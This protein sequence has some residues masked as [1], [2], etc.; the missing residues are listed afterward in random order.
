MR[1]SRIYQCLTIAT[2]VL[3]WL[4]CSGGGTGGN[5]GTI[6]PGTTATYVLFSDG[7][8]VN[9]QSINP[10]GTL[11]PILGSPYTAGVQPGAIAVSP[12]GKWIYVLNGAG[13]ISQFSIASDGTLTSIANVAQTGTQPVAIAIDSQQRYLV[14]ANQGSGNVSIYSINPTTGSLSQL[15]NSPVT[16]GNNP[17]SIAVT[18]NLIYAVAANSIAEIAIDPINYTTTVVNGS[19]FATGAVGTLSAAA[20]GIRLYALDATS[21]CGQGATPMKNCIRDYTFNITNGAPVLDTSTAAGTLP[22]ALLPILNNKFLYVA[23][24]TSSNVSAY[25][26]NQSTGALTEI[27]GSPFADG[28]GT[29]PSSLAFDSV[30]NLL[31]VGNSGASSIAVYSVNTATGTLT[32]TGTRSVGRSVL[33]VAVAKP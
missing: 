26:I 8:Q 11:T 15:S 18:N 33:S 25:S 30:N 21:D 7:T 32:L 17:V 23:N 28:S 14:V 5:F 19:P 29:S 24:K 9:V 16:T 20:A 12:S 22:A 10:N 1:V 6:G 4:S 3:F 31:L 2:L 13:S 27:A